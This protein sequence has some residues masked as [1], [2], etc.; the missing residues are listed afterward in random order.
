M[1]KSYLGVDVGSTTSKC[2][3]IDD[4]RAVLGISLVTE[5]I[6]TE[7]STK[8]V[9][10]VLE[11]VGV[12][13]EDISKT[14][15]TGY[16]RKIF[17]DSDRKVSELSC[18][19][20]GVFSQVPEARTLIDIGGQ[21]AKVMSITESGIMTNF[22]MNDKC[23][24]GTGRFLDVMARILQLDVAQLEGEYFKAAKP[25]KISSTCTVFS[26]SEVISQLASGEKR[27]DVVAGIC[28][29]VATRFASLVMRVGVTPTLCMS[30]GVAKNG[31]VRDALEKEL[32]L[33]IVC[34]PNAQYMGALGAAL[35]AWE[36]E[37]GII[38]L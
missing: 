7:G 38:R 20:K 16:G 33:Q 6:G 31:G 22:Q 19:V 23:A 17:P 4:D 37:H 13:R 8:A 36:T 34:P 3:V 26:E 2:V 32:G 9:S 35:Y 30:G 14:V 29:S 27:E 10:E 21:D 18:H 28:Q 5:G 12:R 24:A 11:Q 15:A 1:S 25:S